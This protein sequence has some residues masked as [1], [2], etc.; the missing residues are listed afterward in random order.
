MIVDIFFSTSG[1][2]VR[3]SPTH[4]YSFSS[5]SLG[6]PG[7]AYR[8]AH[9]ASVSV[10]VICCCVNTYSCPCLMFVM[11]VVITILIIF[12]R[13]SFSETKER[14]SFRRLSITSQNPDVTSNVS[15]KW[16]VLILSADAG[17]RG[18]VNQR[19][20]QCTNCSEN[21]IRYGWCRS[22]ET[23]WVEVV[24]GGQTCLQVFFLASTRNFY[25][26]IAIAILIGIGV[27]IVIV[28]SIT[29]SL[30]LPLPLQSRLVGEALRAEVRDLLLFIFSSSLFGIPRNSC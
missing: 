26:W 11:I 29:L 2:F 23:G 4:A 25:P 24:G 28:I 18:C 17:Q 5:Q 20:W 14:V 30:F 13:I 10:I 16:I 3:L 21:A 27:I 19:R 6:P 1:R 7:V 9:S 12:N 22:S 15:S 8:R